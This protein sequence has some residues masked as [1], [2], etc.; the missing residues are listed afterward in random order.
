MR[1]RNFHYAAQPK[2][3]ELTERSAEFALSD[4]LEGL[5]E[6]NFAEAVLVVEDGEDSADQ[7]RHYA[8]GVVVLPHRE[9]CLEVDQLPESTQILTPVATFPYKY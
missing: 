4:G 8:V 7:H 9:D 3:Y 1:F 2:P 5:K 6:L